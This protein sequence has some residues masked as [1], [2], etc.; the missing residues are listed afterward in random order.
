MLKQP[1]LTFK[2]FH[3]YQSRAIKRGMVMKQAALFI[4][5]GLGKT[6]ITL[7]MI[8]QLLKQGH[9]RKALVVAPLKVVQNVWEQEAQRWEH[10]QYLTFDM[11]RG[12]LE[13]RLFRLMNLR[14]D[15]S[16]INYEMLPWLCDTIRTRFG[17]KV[18]FDFIAFDESTRMKHTGTKRFMKYRRLNKQIPY[19]YVLT[20]T[21]APNGIK[22]IFG[23]FFILDNGLRLGTVA[24]NFKMQYYTHV[25]DY[26]WVQIPGAVK[27]VKRKVEDITIRLAAKDYM[28]LPKLIYNTIPGQLSDHHQREYTKL[29]TEFF[30]ELENTEI[31]AF[32]KASLSMKLRQYVQGRMYTGEEPDR[33]VIDV[34]SEKLDM[35]RDLMFNNKENEFTG[36][37]IA[38]NFRF[39][40]KQLQKLFPKAPYIQG[41]M[42]AGEAQRAIDAWNTREAPVLLVNP[43][44]AAHGL[45]LQTGGHQ[46]IWYSLTWDLEHYD[47]LIRRLYRQ[48]QKKPV[49]IHHLI[50]RNTVDVAVLQAL[51]SKGRTQHDLLAALKRYKNE[52]P[53]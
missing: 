23:Q 38:Y 52:K 26:L 24:D 6:I 16:L 47:Q 2:D 51:K 20:G 3:K 13:D 46:I 30:I 1:V 32:T 43:A 45:N 10:T 9:I 35:L 41:S 11:L 15:I 50:M 5:C 48:G 33:R 27:Q 14:A 44:S 17:G 19:R 21:P 7:T 53:I 25:K 34:H 12:R 37:I 40:L 22:D 4:D 31:E 29:E 49:I 42:R 39:E 8:D 28:E 36:T 18:P